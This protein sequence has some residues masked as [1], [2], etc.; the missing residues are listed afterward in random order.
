VPQIQL[1]KLI[2]LAGPEITT[3]L[4]AKTRPKRL[5]IKVLNSRENLKIK[6]YAFETTSFQNFPHGS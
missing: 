6:I 2:C 4:P 5:Q 1:K 3:S